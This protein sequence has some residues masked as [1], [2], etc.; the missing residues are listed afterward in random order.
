MAR[1]WGVSRGVPKGEMT[2]TRNKDFKR[3]VR[4]RMKK[5]GESYTSARAQITR[6]FAPA[7]KPNTKEYATLAGMSD[8]AIKEK[9]GCTWERWVKALD[10]YGAEK[11]SHRDIA[12]LV[13]EKYKVQSWWT[14]TVTVGYERI[15]GLRARGQ[16]RDGTYEASKSRTFNVP[17]ADLFK[18]W[19]DANLRKRW[20]DGSDVKI[21][22][23][24]APKSLRLGWTDGTIV[25]V[26]F[27][28]KGKTKSSVAVQ[29]TKLPD[30]D[31]ANRLKQYWSERF[32]NLNDVLGNL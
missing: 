18:A 8:A 11:M 9:T 17:V 19:S 2:M 31:T 7:N 16:R 6:K 12:K 30:R 13:S 10:H 26:G 14:Q 4:A 28:P 22:T 27:M 1:C 23:A 20:L 21:R 25:A 5:T 32:D 3:I 24:T 15:K 29:H